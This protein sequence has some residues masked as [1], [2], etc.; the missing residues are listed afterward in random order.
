MFGLAVNEPASVIY[1]GALPPPVT[2]KTAFSKVVVEAIG[3]RVP[4]R[5][6][7]WSREKAHSS[8]FWRLTRARGVLSAVTALLLGGRHRGG[9]LLQPVNSGWG[10]LYNLTLALVGR[11]LGYRLVLHHHGYKYIDRRDFRVAMLERLVGSQDFHIM[12]CDCMMREYTELYATKGSFLRLPPTLV[13][14]DPSELAAES[15]DPA[16][17]ISE[18]ALPSQFTIGFLSNLSLEKGLADVLSTFELIAKEYTDVRMILAGPCRGD[19]EREMIDRV[20]AAYPGRV[21]YCGP[22]YGPEKGAFFES[23]SAFLFPTKSESWGI[24]LNEAMEAGRPVVANARGCI[25]SIVVGE[26]GLVVP[27][28]DDFPGAAA[29]RIAEWLADPRL[30]DSA[31]RAASN[32]AR[33]LRLDAFDCLEVFLDTIEA[34]ARPPSP[35]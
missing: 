9:L 13:A 2:G 12:A 34:A 22:V 18:T 31:S 17:R 35:T 23:I 15:A 27:V 25:P 28:G 16:S 21:E 32:R 24:V 11:L 4:V 7:A 19:Q 3:K 1:A 6:L 8:F 14:A 20:I 5:A 29:A 30:H 10:L 33:Q 26:A